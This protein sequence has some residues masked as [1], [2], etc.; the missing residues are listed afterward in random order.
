ML[1]F[2][3]PQA[4]RVP[5]QQPEH[6]RCH[7]KIDTLDS[8]VHA[9]H[10]GCNSRSDEGNQVVDDRPVHNN[11]TCLFPRLVPPLPELLPMLEGL[12]LPADFSRCLHIALRCPV[13]PQLLHLALRNRHLAFSCP[14]LPQQAHVDITAPISIGVGCLLEST[15]VRKYCCT[16]HCPGLWSTKTYV[17]FQRSF[18]CPFQT[19]NRE[20][21]TSL[22]SQRSHVYLPHQRQRSQPLVFKAVRG[23][24]LELKHV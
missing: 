2:S 19:S 1:N 14:A 11:S 12:D 8:H 5:P 20:C 24:P 15:V 21:L 3:P 23:C 22:V 13:L 17:L 18:L 7:Q 9:C 10:R 4:Q 16:Q 6:L